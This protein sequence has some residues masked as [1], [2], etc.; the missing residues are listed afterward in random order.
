MHSWTLNLRGLAAS[1]VGVCRQ[2]L[3]DA[4]EAGWPSQLFAILTAIFGLASFAL[5]LALI[6]QA[7][8]TLSCDACKLFDHATQFAFQQLAPLTIVGVCLLFWHRPH[9]SQAVAQCPSRFGK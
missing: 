2:D 1:A 8:H 5:V 4:D 7:G 9:V 3:P 6:E